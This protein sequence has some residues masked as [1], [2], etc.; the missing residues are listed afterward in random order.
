MSHDRPL[1]ALL[2]PPPSPLRGWVSLSVLFAA[3]LIGCGNKSDGSPSEDASG[4]LAPM[5]GSGGA[6]G[7]VAPTTGGTTTGGTATGGVVASGGQPLPESGG[8]TASAGQTS[9]GN[10]GVPGSGGEVALGGAAGASGAGGGQVPGGGAGGVEAVCPA[11]A[12]AA[13]LGT[14]AAVPGLVE[15]ENFDTL[16][17]FDTTPGNQG[18]VY[19]TDVDVD[20]TAL[21][22][23]YA[24]TWMTVGEWVEYT[25]NVAAEGDYLI[26]V[27]AGA[28]AAGRTLSLT[29]CDD[30]LTGPIPVPQIANW[31]QTGTVTTDAVHLTAGLHVLRVTAGGGDFLDFD[32]LTFTALDTGVGGAGG[33]GGFAGAGGVSG[34]SGAAGAAG[35]AGAA[36][37]G[38]LVETG[39]VAGAGGEG[40]SAGAAGATG[41]SPCP[42]SASEPCIVLPLGDSITEGYGSSGGGYRVE[43]FRQAVLSG[44]NLTFVGSLTNGPATV[45]G[46]DFPPNHE[47]HGG[48]WIEDGTGHSGIAGAITDDAL[49]QYQP[50][51]VLLMIGTNDINGTGAS[52][53]PTRLGNLI[54]DITSRAPEALVVVSS[55]IPIDNATTNGLVVTYNAA[56]P[57]LVSSRAAA[58]QHV[59]FLD[60]Y[61]AFSADPTFA[62]TLMYDYLHPNDDGY[63]VLGQTFYGA[64][65]TYLP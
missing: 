52:G 41:Y 20:L 16:G 25:V 54:D 39:G 34:A 11:D 29:E 5:G 61:A 35:T 22:V 49:D 1:A 14:P 27:T 44:K 47:G 43:L 46:Q 56:I 13:Y 45:A 15:A 10:G 19:R 40:G 2:S 57:G 63:M 32:S 55:I 60:N 9:G 21:E 28:V 64:I 6:L 7:G 26:T 12:A 42:A 17:Y 50:H 53:A 65:A 24:V 36:G 23:G 8:S 62:D 33:A 4:G 18:D 59:V 58:G 51:I 37:A 3:V 48:F 30:L 31:G 38:G